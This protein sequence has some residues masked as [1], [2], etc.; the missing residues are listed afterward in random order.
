MTRTEI[1]SKFRQENPEVTAN[2]ISDTI[3]KSWLQTGDKETCAKSRLIVGTEEDIPIIEDQSRYDL[4][5]LISK[6]FD[7]DELPGGGISIIDSSNREQRLIKLS[8]SELD[9]KFKGWRTASSGVPKYY[10]RR[11]QYFYIYPAPGSSIQTMNVDFV[12]IS[13]PFDNDD[14]TPFNQRLDLEPFHQALVFYLTWRAKQ[15]LEKPEDAATAMANYNLYLA[16]MEKTIGG[17][18]YGSIYLQPS[19]ITPTRIDR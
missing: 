13:D 4:T 16:W 19:G 10:F 5:S 18:K 8:K 15:K 12:A 11:G 17:S 14:E 2:V 9:V 7:V 3:L 6:F 1:I